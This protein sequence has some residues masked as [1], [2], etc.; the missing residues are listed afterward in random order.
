MTKKLLGIVCFLAAFLA[1]VG[2]FTPKHQNDQTSFQLTT[3]LTEPIYPLIL[4]VIGVA[5][6]RWKRETD[7]SAKYV[8]VPRRALS[9]AIDAIL[10][11]FPFVYIQKAVLHWGF[12]PYYLFTI[13]FAVILVVLNIFFLC[14]F[15]GTPGKLILGIRIVKDSLERLTLREAML[16]NIVDIALTILGIIG[17][18]IAY[19]SIDF[20]QYQEM[21]SKA[22]AVY[23]SGRY[24]LWLLIQLAVNQYWVWS[25]IVVMSFNAR[26]KAIHDYIAGTVVIYKS[27]PFA[28]LRN[29]LYQKIGSNEDIN[30]LVESNT[31]TN[32]S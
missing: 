14:N 19:S 6:F 22:R 24:P 1:F 20:I 2:Q 28:K 17:L 15:G 18:G 27:I 30:N 9:M 25:E 21:E 26:R 29:G 23:I 12:W 10:V 4:I 32:A 11:L 13:S 7:D 5:A 8:D 31:D 16:R 3:A